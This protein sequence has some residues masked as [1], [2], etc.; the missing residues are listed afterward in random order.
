[1]YEVFANNLL[2]LHWEEPRWRFAAFGLISA[3]LLIVTV[4]VTIALWVADAFEH[5]SLQRILGVDAILLAAALVALVCLFALDAVQVRSGVRA[6][7]AAAFRTASVMAAARAL[8]CAVAL[9]GLGIAALRVT[10]A[11]R[12]AEAQRSGRAA[13]GTVPL[14]AGGRPTADRG[15]AEGADRGP[16]L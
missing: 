13:K 2:P 9:A 1:V 4:G 7:A 11:A 16:M 3:S 14:V 12:V 15:T 8:T 6:E 10:K 5:R